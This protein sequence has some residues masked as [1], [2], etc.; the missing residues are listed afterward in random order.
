MNK[1]HTKCPQKVIH[2]GSSK[3][4]FEIKWDNLIR[5]KYSKHWRCQKAVGYEEGVQ[6][7]NRNPKEEEEEEEEE[8][9]WTEKENGYISG[10]L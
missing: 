5:G 2:I 8:N 9:Y 7:N 1:L 4:Q 3:N 6:E 10:T